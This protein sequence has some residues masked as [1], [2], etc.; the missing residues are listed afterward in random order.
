MEE[1]LI[2]LNPFQGRAPKLIMIDLTNFAL[3]HGKKLKWMW[4]HRRVV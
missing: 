2:L 3:N 1:R 4:L